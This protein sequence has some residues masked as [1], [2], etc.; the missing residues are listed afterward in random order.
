MTTYINSIKI[1]KSK[2][3]LKLKGKLETIIEELKK[4]QK[5]GWI[6]FEIKERKDI[7]K[8]GETH[9]VTLDEFEP[10][11]QTSDLPI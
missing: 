10:K 7:G 3:G 4:T 1:T 8:F 2:F 9:T 6:N 11:K 5:N